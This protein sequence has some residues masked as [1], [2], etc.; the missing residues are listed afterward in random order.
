MSGSYGMYNGYE[1]CEGTPVPGKEE[2]LDSEK[3]QYKVWDWNRPGNIKGFIRRINEIRRE[4]RAL[5][6]FKNLVF[7]DSNNPGILTYS[8][9][10]E[11]NI[12]LFV[13]NLDPHHKQAATVSL[14]LGAMGLGSE[15]IYGLYDLL[16][17]RKLRLVG[18]A[19][20]RGTDAAEGGSAHLQG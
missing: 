17:P 9:T 20:L 16:D 2:Y 7:H 8:K 1:L 14:N 5:H 12:L 6:Y 19:Q 11:E 3:Y 10:H 18:T 4:N 15:N 13:V